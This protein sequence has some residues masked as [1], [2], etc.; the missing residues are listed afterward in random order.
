MKSTNFDKFIEELAS[1]KNILN[2]C[3][4]I[5]TIQKG[6]KIIK[7][8]EKIL[9]DESV[10]NEEGNFKLLVNKIDNLAKK[11]ENHFRDL[12][13]DARNELDGIW[14]DVHELTERVDDLESDS[15]E[16]NDAIR[17]IEMSEEEWNDVRKGAMAPTYDKLIISFKKGGSIVFSDNWTDYDYVKDFIVVKNNEVWIAMYNADDVFSVVLN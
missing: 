2:E 5:E 9:D 10:N 12:E 4:E 1:L 17:K 15:M 6:S 7:A 16:Y 8:C 13:S 3:E 11:T 14:E